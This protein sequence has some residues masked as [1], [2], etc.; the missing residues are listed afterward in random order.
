MATTVKRPQLAAAKPAPAKPAAQA[1]AVKKE[2]NLATVE[3]NVPV[4]MQK[5]AGKGTEN[6]NSGDYEMP[7]VKLLQGLSDELTTFDGLKAGDFFHT[8]GEANLSNSVQIVPLYIS[9]RFVLWRPRHDGGGILARS[10]DAVHWNPP[11]GEFRVKPYKDND[12]QVIWKL[13]PTVA[14]SRLDQ[15]GTYDPADPK[16]PPAATQAFVIIVYLPE[17]PEL[18]PVALL[19]QRTAIVPARRLLGKLRMSQAPIYGMKI[20]MSSFV[21]NRND[22]KFN[23]Y[24]FQMDGYVENKDEYEMYQRYNEQFTKSGVKVKDLEESQEDMPQEGS[25]AEDTDTKEY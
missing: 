12:K 22:Q 9:K 10:D 20:R 4:F 15:W 3:S 13:A 21:D 17:H 8:L 6:L 25:S 18:S 5:D 16:S 1:V 2:N 23:N 11:T 24:Q 14:A 7:R 19:L